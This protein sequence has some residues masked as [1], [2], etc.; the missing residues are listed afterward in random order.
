M[1]LRDLEAINVQLE[2]PALFSLTMNELTHL[3]FCSS[4]PYVTAPTWHLPWPKGMTWNN[5][6]GPHT[7]SNR[8][9][10]VGPRST[11]CVNPPGLFCQMLWF[12]H[13]N[14]IAET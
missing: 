13:L 7:S 2:M 9:P 12:P 8:L 1:C 5:P 4:F 11:P 10:V 14:V 6:S 3:V